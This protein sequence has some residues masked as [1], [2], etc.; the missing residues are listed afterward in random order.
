[1]SNFAVIIYSLLIFLVVLFIL[2]AN[3]RIFSLVTYFCISYILIFVLSPINMMYFGDI[4]FDYFYEKSLAISLIGIL[5]FTFGYFTNLKKQNIKRKNIKSKNHLIYFKP[6]ENFYTVYIISILLL[7]MLLFYILFDVGLSSHLVKSIKSYCKTGIGAYLALIIFSISISLSI[8]VQLCVYKKYLRWF[9][10]LITIVFLVVILLFFGSRVHIAS[11]LISNLIVYSIKMKRI[12]IK[13]IAFLFCLFFIYSYV[14]FHIRGSNNMYY[15]FL[16]NK[17]NISIY[18]VYEQNISR[19][20]ISKILSDIVCSID[21]NKIQY[22]AGWSYIGFFTRFLPRSF[23]EEKAY[24]T[25]GYVT[26]ILYPWWRAGD[27]GSSVDP[28]IIG[29]FYL[30]GGIAFV[31]MGM[32]YLGLI[33]KLIDK[34]IIR[35][36]NDFLISLNA[37]LSVQILGI[38]L[39]GINSAASI[40][41][42]A[43][44][45]IFQFYFN[46]RQYSRPKPNLFR[47]LKKN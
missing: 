28:S 1:M 24:D 26:R 23:I 13:M 43:L 20:N 44:I 2:S 35:F 3:K 30:N 36:E 14:I 15:S 38:T 27:G 7:L 8:Y 22:L 37:I 17:E 32:Y 46:I 11:I 16:N 47:A 40:R 34:N 29:E 42:I 45:F 33:L 9:V 18:S 41:I 10:F 19:F 31:V 39:G 5:S 12:P 4:K 6:K 25:G 21:K